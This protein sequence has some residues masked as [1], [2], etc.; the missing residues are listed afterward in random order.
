M[1]E[2]EVLFQTKAEGV[3]HVE[4]SYSSLN[5]R[6]PI[7]SIRTYESIKFTANVNM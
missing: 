6:T 1:R 7:S 5:E 3:Y 2:T 4:K